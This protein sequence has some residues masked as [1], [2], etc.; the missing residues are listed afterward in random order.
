[1]RMIPETPPLWCSSKA[2]RQLFEW[3]RT[4]EDTD[5][6][7]AMHSVR[8]QGAHRY[9]RMAELDFLLLTPLGILV[10]EVKGG[11]VRQQ[12]PGKWLYQDGTGRINSKHEGPFEQAEGGLHALERWLYGRPEMAGLSSTL[13]TGWGVAMPDM[14]PV[15]WGAGVDPGQIYDL[16]TRGRSVRSVVTEMLEVAKRASRVQSRRPP[17]VEERELIIHGLFGELNTI[18]ELELGRR[19]AAGTLD[20]LHEHMFESLD[21]W[22][23]HPRLMIHTPAGTGGA[24]LAA[25]IIRR[26]AASHDAVGLLAPSAHVDAIRGALGDARNVAVVLDERASPEALDA[27]IVYQAHALSHERLL[28][29]MERL[30]AGAR[31]GHWVIM[32]DARNLTHT[33][34]PN[35]ARLLNAWSASAEVQTLVHNVCHTTGITRFVN[36]VCDP[37]LRLNSRV[38]GPA[39]QLRPVGDPGA[40]AASLA[41]SLD[42]ILGE[43]G[44]PTEHVMVLVARDCQREVVE[45]VLDEGEI[46]LTVRTVNDASGLMADVV[47]LVG[48]ERL[49]P[50]EWRDIVYAGVSS[51]RYMA[52]LHVGTRGLTDYVEMAS[53]AFAAR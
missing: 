8:L 36:M 11:R 23:H 41:A 9:K 10:L 38:P 28:N 12:A 44:V 4:S 43:G 46:A 49:A 47:L 5:G 51:A 48:I 27:L 39:V 7:I 40:L 34:P 33:V 29:A 17:T 30:E 52:V 35:A 6:W 53:A 32:H 16:A 18:P 13:L 26:R 15:D 31:A 1:M 24:A 22:G 21:T 37:A 20:A 25:E 50:S 42:E 14:P 19:I 45:A 2:E 3:F